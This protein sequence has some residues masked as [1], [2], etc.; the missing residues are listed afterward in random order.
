MS[1][2]DR[3]RERAE[4]RAAKRGTPLTSQDV[5][6]EVSELPEAV[7]EQADAL[8]VAITPKAPKKRSNE[9]AVQVWIDDNEY[10]FT[11]KTNITGSFLGTQQSKQGMQRVILEALRT[12][13]GAVEQV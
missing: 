13:F 6:D 12:K 9:I 11:F 10:C 8:I 7:K 1:E 3:A 5:L 4:R 2:F